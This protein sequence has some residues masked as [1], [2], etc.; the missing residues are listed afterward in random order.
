MATFQ[1]DTSGNLAL[2]FKYEAM[3]ADIQ[4]LRRLPYKDTSPNPNYYAEAS[5]TKCANCQRDIIDGEWISKNHNRTP[6]EGSTRT[7]KGWQH[8]HINCNDRFFLPGQQR[9]Q[10]NTATQTTVNVPTTPPLPDDAADTQVT[11]TDAT[12]TTDNATTNNGD[13]A[14]LLKAILGAVASVYD[15]RLTDVNNRIDHIGRVISESTAATK[16][17]LESNTNALGAVGAMIDIL[18]DT[19]AKL[20]TRVEALEASKPITLTIAT[21]SNHTQTI[22]IGLAHHK[23]PLLVKWAKSLENGQRNIW[24]AGPAGSGKT[25]AAKQLA[26]VLFADCKCDT[27]V[28]PSVS[29]YDHA[30]NHYFYTGAIDTEYKLSGFIDANGVIHNTQFKTAWREGGVFLFDEIDR[31]LTGALLKFNAALANAY[32][33]FP[34]G[35]IKRN[36]NC[37][38]LA[39]ANTWGFGGDANYVGANKIDAAFLS[40]FV[41]KISWQYDTDLELA[42]V[43]TDAKSQSWTRAVQATRAEA[44]NYGAAVVI[45]PRQS[46]AG[47]QAIRANILTPNEIFDSVFGYLISANVENIDEIIKPMRDWQTNAYRDQAAA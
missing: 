24:I 22:K 8:W 42:L 29:A 44:F 1:A 41:P 45:D 5:V 34:E 10:T 20:D 15:P 47:A 35:S 2:A 38:I 11:D 4:K 32:C 14:E 12:Q 37:Y 21:S 23:F 18:R 36:P 43:G 28:A 46:I 7:F 16:T 13:L 19:A 9:T 40:R 6:R 33:D 17:A 31:S 39:A 26:G 3:R 25:H 30:E 27:C